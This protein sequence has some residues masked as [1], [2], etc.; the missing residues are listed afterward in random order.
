[1]RRT[2]WHFV[3][4]GLLLILGIDTSQAFAGQTSVL[5]DEIHA[6]GGQGQAQ[7]GGGTALISDQSALAIN[8]AMLFRHKNYDVNGTYTWP[9]HG[10]PFYKVSAVDGITSKFATA[11]EFTG[12]TEGLE[13]RETRQQD[14]PVRR[15]ASLGFSVPGQSSAFGFAAHYVEAQDP[16]SST[17]KS[18]K[19]FTLGAGLAFPLTSGL[20]FGASAQ[21]L[22]NKNVKEVSPRT[23]RAGFAWQDKAE[24]VGFHFDYRDRERSSYLEEIPLSESGVLAIIDTKT[25]PQSLDSEKMLIAGLELRTMDIVRIFMSGGKSVSGETRQVAS[26]GLGLFQKNFSVAYMI[27]KTSPDSNELQN[28]LNLSITMKL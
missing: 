16:A 19:G 18:I 9:V 3:L 8:P 11:F 21:N 15:R 4:N 10:R 14:S 1:M 13:D 24:A 17:D 5:P 6:T 22:N 27:S 26:G 7:S 12:F 20:V 25:K 28:S 2:K 23:L